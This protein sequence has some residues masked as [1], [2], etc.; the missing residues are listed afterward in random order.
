MPDFS[1]EAEEVLE[2]HYPLDEIEGHLEVEVSLTENWGRTFFILHRDG[3][4][5]ITR[6][7]LMDP[8]EK[9]QLLPRVEI[10]ERSF[11][12]FMTVFTP[13]GGKYQLQLYPRDALIAR[14][15]ADLVHAKAPSLPA[16]E[17]SA[18]PAPSGGVAAPGRRNPGTS[19][20]GGD[21]PIPEVLPDPHDPLDRAGNSMQN[22]FE[23][24]VVKFSGSPEDAATGDIRQENLDEA[25]SPEFISLVDTGDVFSRM[26][27]KTAQAISAYMSA[28]ERRTDPEVALKLAALYEKTGDPEHDLLWRERAIEQ[29]KP[30]DRRNGLIDRLSERLR[31]IG[32]SKKAAEWQS[33][34]S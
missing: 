24:M 20:T 8:F 9:I 34:K 13:D 27:A 23:R 17:V 22:F 15:L 2:N 18:P 3:F 4:F 33:R 28:W 19:R 5:A 1:R 16:P 31:E 21:L 6:K 25:P 12:T 10:R 29:M 7:N 30:G 26:P 32:S 14:N 11:E